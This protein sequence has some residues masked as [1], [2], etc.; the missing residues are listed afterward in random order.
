MLEN[1][2]NL[3]VMSTRKIDGYE[4]DN[5]RLEIESQQLLK[6]GEHLMLTH[7]AFQMLLILVQKSGQI[8][9]KEDIYNQ[10]WSDSFVE[11]ANLTQ[12]IYVLRKTLG[13]KPN[14]QPY[15]ETVNRRGYRFNSEVQ[16]IVSAETLPELTDLQLP[17]SNLT[18]ENS[19]YS[20]SNAGHLRLVADDAPET[21]DVPDAA[22]RA[23]L[24]ITSSSRIWL[25]TGLSILAVVG[26]LLGLGWFA[27]RQTPTKQPAMA[28]KDVKSIAVLPFKPIGDESTEEKLGLGMADAVITRL[29]KLQLIPVRSTSAV[30]RFTDNPDQNPSDAGRELGVEAVLEGTVQR[31]GERIRVSVQLVN[32][33]DGKP[34]WAEH[35]DEKSKDI[36][37]IQ[38]S[39]SAKVA[40]AL[41]FKL[42][43]QQW[44]VIEQRPT[45][46]PAAFQAYQLGVYFWNKRTKDDLQKAVK[47][48]QQ[49]IELDPNYAQAYAMLADSYNM[50][51]YYHFADSAEMLTKARAAAEKSL[52][53][54]D[55][56]AEAHIA[57][58]FVQGSEP[59]G[60]MTAR[61]SLE[62][63]IELA[64]YNSTAH[65]RYGWNLLATE[66][67]DGTVR[68]MRLAQEYDP[69]SLVSNNT[70]CTVLI[71]QHKFD[72]AIK[73]C[74]R[75][76]ELSPNAPSN[77]LALAN[78]YFFNGRINDAI[79]QAKADIER[80]EEKNTARGSLAFFYAKTGRTAEAEEIFKQLKTVKESEILSD[81]ILVSYALG[82]KDE[83]F[84]Y[85]QQAYEKKVLPYAMFR[86]DPVWDELRND[87]R[88]T[89]LLKE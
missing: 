75:A 11:D 24:P 31:A 65:V 82:K 22:T 57:I 35:F 78:A 29:S 74:E 16:K 33:A 55:S 1:Q 32:V 85:F 61:R 2:R 28:A 13:Q 30:F 40:Q 84:A 23:Q 66:N 53:L 15:I 38:D 76:V 54:N 68:E 72:E 81:L 43:P 47:N 34:L 62:R 9:E 48:F 21:S 14:G 19:L 79:D 86:Y 64:P 26:L 36:F 44:H 63:A 7:K 41:A 89:K 8:I 60:R 18:D 87:E 12:Y 10:L 59:Y 25:T 46:A 73:Y 69:L 50:L 6:N 49:A 17:A 88:F 37:A 51:G 83:S 70:L 4:F 5:F 27:Y 3:Y 39:I 67:L 52:A 77:K 58:A 56:L 71:F 45:T 80:G 20:R 42:T